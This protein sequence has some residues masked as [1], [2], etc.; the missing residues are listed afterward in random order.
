M[1][2]AIPAGADIIKSVLP[3]TNYYTVSKY[4]LGL[5]MVEKKRVDLLFLASSKLSMNEV[6]KLKNV[7]LIKDKSMRFDLFTALSKNALTHNSHLEKLVAKFEK[8]I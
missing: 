5:K 7:T 1:I 2:L 3:K 8:K 6:N 4:E